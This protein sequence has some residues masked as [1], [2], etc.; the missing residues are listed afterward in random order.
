VKG[1][2]VATRTAEA[3][4][5]KAVADFLYHLIV[6]LFIGALLVILDVRAGTADNAILGLD[7]AYWVLLFWGLGLAGHAVSAF[8]D[9]RERDTDRLP[10]RETVDH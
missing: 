7:W 2:N 10:E 3:R 4:R 5:R 1:A 9:D 6:Y 8:F